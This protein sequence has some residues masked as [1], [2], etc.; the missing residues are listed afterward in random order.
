MEEERLQDLYDYI[1]EM[2][3]GDI[4]EEAWVEW[5]MEDFGLVRPYAKEVIQNWKRER[6]EAND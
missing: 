6:G 2:H 1:D 5:L 3:Y 4:D